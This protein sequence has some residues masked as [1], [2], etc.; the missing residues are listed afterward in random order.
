M[1]LLCELCKAV[2]HQFS[3]GGKQ[4]TISFSCSVELYVPIYIFRSRLV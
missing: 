3:D 2:K 4:Y 1:S